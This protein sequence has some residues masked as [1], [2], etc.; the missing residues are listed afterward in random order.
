V[1]NQHPAHCIG[2][3][4]NGSVSPETDSELLIHESVSRKAKINV[5]GCSLSKVEES[6]KSFKDV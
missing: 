5:A 2:P 4:S 1:A 6:R 3:D